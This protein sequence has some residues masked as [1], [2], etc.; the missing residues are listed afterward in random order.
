MRYL[1]AA[2]SKSKKTNIRLLSGACG[3][4]IVLTALILQ[5]ALALRELGVQIA[6][7]SSMVLAMLLLGNRSHFREGWFWR[8]FL[9]TALLHVG[10]VYASRPYLPFSNLGI[11]ILV[12]VPEAIVLFTVL[13]GWQVIQRR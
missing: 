3:G 1:R 10:I 8:G 11:V 12:S 4:A 13:L 5:D 9:I 6:I 7:W 2:T